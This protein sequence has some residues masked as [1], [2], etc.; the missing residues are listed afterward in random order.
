MER[1]GLYE[2]NY[3]QPCLSYY[4]SLKKQKQ[5]IRGVIPIVVKQL[6]LTHESAILP[7]CKKH[8]VTCI[9]VHLYKSIQ[10][11]DDL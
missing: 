10:I 7:C 1:N 6:G 5:K 8:L 9:F 4:F 3:I 2:E 11:I